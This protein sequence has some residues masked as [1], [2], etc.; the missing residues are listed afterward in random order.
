[1]TTGPRNV[2]LGGMTDKELADL[3]K[4]KRF[5]KKIGPGQ[6]NLAVDAR[7]L[8]RDRKAKREKARLAEFAKEREETVALL[9]ARPGRDATLLSKGSNNPF[10]L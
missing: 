9:K 2:D 3:S 10:R 5:N 1:M 4:N 7:N 8:L 6:Q